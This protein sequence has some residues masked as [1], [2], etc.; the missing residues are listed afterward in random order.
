MTTNVMQDLADYRLRVQAWLAAQAVEFGRNARRGLTEADDLALGRRW[1]R[2]KADAGYAGISWPKQY[3]GAG[4]SELQQAIF[5]EEE[6]K[7]GFPMEYFG[8]SLGQPIPIMLRR[9]TEAQKQRY[10]LPALRG[11][12]IWCQLFSEPAA[13]SD[14]AGL[15]LR[16]RQD[17][18]TWVLSGQKLWT[19]WAQY[20]DFGV[21]VARSDPSV[22]KHKGLTYFW[23]DMRAPGITVR[24]VRLAEGGSHVN[25]VFF[26]DV[27][28]P[29]SQRLGGIGEGFAVAMETLFIER[30]SAAA[31]ETGFGPPLSLFLSLAADSEYAGQAAIKDGRIRHIIAQAYRTQKAL[32]TIRTRS[33]LELA[34][35]QEPGPEGSIH[36]LVS[37]RARQILGASA[38]DLMGP[39]GV[40]L[41]PHGYSKDDWAHSW[42]AAPTG[43]IAGGADEMLLNTIA[44][45]ILG[46]PQDYRPDKGIPF[47]QIEQKKA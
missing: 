39:A 22:P 41:D 3:G 20:S 47:D 1:Q 38:L 24:P 6:I 31:D 13:G 19:S 23:L 16:A 45:K 8:I 11:E 27:R 2:L 43:R 7:L 36:K 14:L 9:A 44:E 10:V 34:A 21:V 32:V 35:G 42:L 17:G 18:D 29:D 46:L 4:G 30:Y 33:Y 26:D 25:E 40:V 5:A 28:I 12:E 37:M 15:R